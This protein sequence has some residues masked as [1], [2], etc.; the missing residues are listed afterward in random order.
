MEI[1]D[2]CATAP[3]HQHWTIVEKNVEAQGKYASKLDQHYKNKKMVR[4]TQ[5]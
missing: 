3:F 5:I 2:L 4:L 1:E